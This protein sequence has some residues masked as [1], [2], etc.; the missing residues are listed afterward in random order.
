MSTLES[1][2]QVQ[3]LLLN[4]KY[5]KCTSNARTFFLKGVMQRVTVTGKEVKKSENGSYYHAI[6][7]VK[8]QSLRHTATITILKFL[9]PP[10]TYPDIPVCY[11]YSYFLQQQ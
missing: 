9:T 2:Y 3:L 7:I 6:K 8:W 4:P 10:H 1:K 11:E 5:N